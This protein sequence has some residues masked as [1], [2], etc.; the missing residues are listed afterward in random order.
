MCIGG[1]ICVVLYSFN[2]LLKTLVLVESGMVCVLLF[3]GVLRA[4]TLKSIL[5]VVLALAALE[6]GVGFTLLVKLLRIYRR[7]SNIFMLG[8]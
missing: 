1:L 6:A 2:H 3:F 8:L 4:L 5:L 7:P